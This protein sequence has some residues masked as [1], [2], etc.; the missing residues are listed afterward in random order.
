[1]QTK[2]FALKMLSSQR[3]GEEKPVSCCYALKQNKARQ[4]NSRFITK[5]KP[6]NNACKTMY[7]KYSNN[8][9]RQINEPLT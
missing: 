2:T 3:S 4:R 7:F 1:M 5:Q 8:S 6:Q 9:L